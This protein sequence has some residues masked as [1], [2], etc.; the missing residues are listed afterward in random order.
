MEALSDHDDTNAKVSHRSLAVVLLLGP[1]VAA[2]AG[3]ACLSDQLA[4]ACMRLRTLEIVYSFPTVKWQCFVTVIF[5]SFGDLCTSL[6][7]GFS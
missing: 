3:H 4:T 2:A 7:M 6:T 5:S 1:S